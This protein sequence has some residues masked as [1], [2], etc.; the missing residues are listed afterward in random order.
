MART[1]PVQGRI[2]LMPVAASPRV[3][4]Q[5]DGLRLHYGASGKCFAAFA[6]NRL[7]PFI[8]RLSLSGHS[9]SPIHFMKLISVNIGAAAS[10]FV[11]QGQETH[12]VMTGIHKQPVTGPV[13]VGRLGLAGDEQVD[14][15]IHGG[16]DKAVYAYPVEHYRFWNTHRKTLLHKNEPLAHGSMGENLTLEGILENDVWIGDRL[17]I[18]GVLMEV[19]EPRQPCFKFN[20]RM[21]FS[22]ASKFM[23]QGGLTGFY[24]RVLEPG[25]VEAGAPIALQPGARDVSI[26][27]INRRRLQGRQRE[28]FD[29]L[30]PG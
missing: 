22:H 7:L 6:A 19:T 8:Y 15:S 12:R 13:Q 9:F 26:A 23:L 21:G 1:N 14:L 3:G 25:T 30:F 18:G 24:L 27:S 16:L 28:L 11:R 29:E 4:A 17:R 5:G 20:V 10:L 2:K